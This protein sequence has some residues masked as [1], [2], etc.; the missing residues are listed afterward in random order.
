MAQQEDKG[1]K[2]LRD[3][4]R[5][6]IGDLGLKEVAGELLLPAG[7]LECVLALDKVNG[8]LLRR[9]R[10]YRANVDGRTR[11]SVGK[12]CAALI[13]IYAE[14]RADF[15]G[16]DYANSDL[17]G[18]WLPGVNLSFSDI[19]G[20]NLQ[21][22]WLVGSELKMANLEKV[23]LKGGNLSDCDLTGAN[24]AGADLTDA[25]LAL[26]NLSHA[27][28]EAA[29]ARGACLAAANLTGAKLKGARF[30]GADLLCADLTGAFIDGAVFDGARLVG[31]K[32]PPGVTV[33]LES[34]DSQGQDRGKRSGA[35]RG[36]AAD[37]I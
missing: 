31:A 27:N 22:A 18:V 26:A 35:E 8:A 21:D 1:R 34:E 15:G 13:E 4:L 5:D 19:R 36:E 28:F 16:A 6:R 37:A 11:Q 12:A 17:H 29:D 23:N 24:L 10:D 30:D 14:G 3:W 9:L 33:R 7:T 25:G 32:L 2:H 20:A